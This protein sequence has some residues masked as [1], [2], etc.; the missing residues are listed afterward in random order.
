MRLPREE[1][2]MPSPLVHVVLGP[3]LALL[4]PG[5]GE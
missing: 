4:H 1:V 3:L 5:G 2:V